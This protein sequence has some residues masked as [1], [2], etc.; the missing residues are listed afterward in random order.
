LLLIINY[1][2]LAEKETVNYP[3]NLV[4]RIDKQVNLNLKAIVKIY[5]SVE[6]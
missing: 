1:L 4:K 6:I 3:Y 2:K 5:K